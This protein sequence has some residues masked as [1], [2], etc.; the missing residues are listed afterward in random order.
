MLPSALEY[1]TNDPNP[2]A[3][4]VL[5]N[6]GP[7][8]GVAPPRP[9]PVS[10]RRR[11]APTPSGH[12]APCPNQGWDRLAASQSVDLHRVGNDAKRIGVATEVG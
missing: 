12:G 4:Y 9:N 7:R 3:D 11:H 8:K 1:L 5:T 6:Y 2:G 10:A